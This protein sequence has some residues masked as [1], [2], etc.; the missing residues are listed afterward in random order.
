VSAALHVRFLSADDV[1]QLVP[2]PAE[3]IAAI[4]DVVRAQGAGEVVLEPR[5]HLEPGAEFRGHWNVLRTYVRPLGT[6]G[7]KVVG[8][9]VDN[10][11]RGLPSEL[12]LVMLFDPATG[13]PTAIVDAELIT[14]LRTG[15]LTTVGAKYLARPDARV[16]GHVGARGTAFWNVVLL[17]ALFGFDE[18]R[19]TSARAESREEFG[20]RLEERL[21]KPVR[22]VDSVRET[23]EGA[24][25]VVEATR[26]VE[27]DPIL[28]TAWLADGG[29][30]VPYGTVSAVELDLLDAIDKVVV[31]DW[32]QCKPG[33]RFGSLREHV[34]R[35]LLT[36]ESLHAELGEIVVGSKPGRERDDERI[37]FWHRGL[38]SCDVALAD[39]LLRRADE[40]GVGTTLLYRS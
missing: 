12:G 28:R 19:V 20:R 2:A 13:A 21:E 23:V 1:A 39:L 11:L 22:V 32:E 8:D 29:F 30:V 26:L 10:H 9:F 27:P 34:D 18:I 31:D 16:L 4:E 3:T 6:A 35:G 15:A 33:G 17:D 40:A 24:D 5:V 25:V 38:A 7:V 36:R 14:S 37:L